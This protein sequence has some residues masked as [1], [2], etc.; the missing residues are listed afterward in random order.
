ME[1]SVVVAIISASASIVVAAISF[2]LNKRAERKATLQQRKPEFKETRYKC[3]IIP[4]LSSLDD[5]VIYFL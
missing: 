5:I 4:I 3:I 1:T 2:V